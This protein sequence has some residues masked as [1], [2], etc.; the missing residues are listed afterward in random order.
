MFWYALWKTFRGNKILIRRGILHQTKST[1]KDDLYLYR[2][3]GTYEGITTT[4]GKPEWEKYSDSN[5]VSSTKYTDN[6]GYDWQGLRIDK[7][8]SGFIGRHVNHISGRH[9]FGGEKCEYKQ[10]LKSKDEPRVWKLD[11]TGVETSYCYS[12]NN[13]RPNWKVSTTQRWRLLLM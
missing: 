11:S 2:Y 12:Q 5:G 1:K 6:E 3:K 7:E 10:R 13:V 9:Y 4:E 8:I